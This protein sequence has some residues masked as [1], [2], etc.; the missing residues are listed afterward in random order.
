M[1]AP[2][3]GV[4]LAVSVKAEPTLALEPLEGAVKDTAVEATAVTVI[5]LEVTLVPL[6]S[7]TLAVS[8]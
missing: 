2:L 8:V 6:E 3:T 1:V 4:A 7:S 5:P